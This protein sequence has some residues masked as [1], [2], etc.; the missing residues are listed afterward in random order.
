[1]LFASK[2][3]L[4][5]GVNFLPLLES[6]NSSEPQPWSNSNSRVAV[7]FA[8]ELR[9][10]DRAH[11]ERLVEQT[12]GTDVFVSTYPEYR[13]IAERL[14][15]PGASAHVRIEARGDDR[16]IGDGK[17]LVRN[18]PRDGQVEYCEAGAVSWW[19]RSLENPTL[20]KGPA[21]CAAS[22]G[23]CKRP[24]CD[25]APGGPQLCCPQMIRRRGRGCATPDDVGCL[26]GTK[27]FI[28]FLRLKQLHYSQQWRM[29]DVLLREYGDFLVRAR[30]V[31]RTR[32]DVNLIYAR[33]GSAV[34]F[35][36]LRASSAHNVDAD[37]DWMLYANG[38]TF[39]R[40]FGDM[41]NTIE[42]QY[43]S[44]RPTEN[45]IEDYERVFYEVNNFPLRE[46]GCLSPRGDS[47]KVS[48]KTPLAIAA[49]SLIG[50]RGGN[51]FS[52]EHA[53]AYHVTR[54]GAQCR[55][56]AAAL[57]HVLGDLVSVELYE[58]RITFAWLT[59]G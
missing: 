46:L 6:R 5:I 28:K 35:A 19:N 54:H 33:N 25:S 13:G 41:V 26:L 16:R 53:L 9:I 27:P 43:E 10:R 45:E 3:R 56:M 30:T 8:G 7:L 50:A 1:M 12:R 31:I 11:L 17:Q 20:K 36:R 58:D 49:W 48:Q 39:M 44:R 37:T 29:L 51:W 18:P 4:L 21:C 42:K 24:S 23:A 32:T 34:P 40:V 38:R 2:L 55:D 57:R 59:P 22:C 14:V 15:G 52:S 47:P